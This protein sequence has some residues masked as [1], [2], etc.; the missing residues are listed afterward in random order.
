MVLKEGAMLIKLFEPAQIGELSLRNRIVM[1]PM[2]VNFGNADGSVSEDTKAYYAER[3]KGG[4]GLITVEATAVTTNGRSS[5]FQLR[6]DKDDFIGGLR[7][8]TGE[9]HRYGAKVSIQLVHC[10]RQ[11]AS[12]YTG[13]QPVAPSPIPYAGGEIPRELSIHEIEDLIEKFAE[14]AVRAKEA[15]FDAIEI[16]GAHGYIISEFL[17]PRV[18]KRSDRYGGNLSGRTAFPLEVVKRTRTS[19]GDHFTIFFRM[20]ADEYLPDGLTINETSAIAVMLQ[21]AGVD[22]IDVSAGT[23]ESLDMFVQPSSLPPG[24][25]VHLASAIKKVVTIPVITVGRIGDPLLAETILRQGKADLIAMGRALIADPELPKKAKE[26]RFDEIRPCLA[27]RSC[28][29]RLLQKSKV[30]CV[31]NASFGQEKNLPVPSARRRKKVLVIGGGPA[32]LEAARIAALRGHEVVLYEKEDRLGGQLRLASVPLYKQGI[33][34]LT[35]FFASQMARLGVEVHVGRKV[36]ADI[37]S[38]IGPDAVVVATGNIPIIPDIR[39]VERSNVSLAVDI[40]AGR[41]MAGGTT[42]IIGGGQIGCETADFLA[43]MGK[44]VTIVEILNDV[45]IDMGPLARIPLLKRLRERGVNIH[46]NTTIEEISER[47]V[48]AKVDAK[49]ISLD[50]ESIILATGSKSNGELAKQLAKEIGE[51][52]V[53]GDCAEPRKVY[54]A[55]HEG[56]QVGLKI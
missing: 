15:G 33:S 53:I 21:E 18:N 36:T 49:I 25:L 22:C 41:K 9:V 47:G 50:A 20:S 27:C 40:L 38:E 34:S 35:K 13:E 17:S 3:A 32:G 4:V 23:M 16:H 30:T 52:Y 46:T 2:V 44:K 24:C 1:P 43:A 26:G 8:L 31:V 55:I 56:F 29:D 48:L 42:I 37:V 10:G 51:L 14:A 5:P 54:D 11:G 19:V 28:F 6:I 39:G 7:S 12:K 45:A